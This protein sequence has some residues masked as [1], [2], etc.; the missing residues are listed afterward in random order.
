MAGSPN[1]PEFSDALSPTDGTE[2][3]R[4]VESSLSELQRF[5]KQ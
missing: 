4:N 5:E 3:Q 1:G 2:M